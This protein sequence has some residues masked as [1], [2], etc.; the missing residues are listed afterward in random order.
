MSAKNFE[1]N[2]KNLKG[3]FAVEG[4]AISEESIKTLKR[5]DGGIVS[6]A[7][8]IEELKHKYM[9]RA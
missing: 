4:M 2:L 3:T 6:Y 1:R 7:D 8:A 5:I 9:Q